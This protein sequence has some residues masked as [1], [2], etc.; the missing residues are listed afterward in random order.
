MEELHKRGHELRVQGKYKEAIVIFKNAWTKDN[1]NK[2]LGWEYAYS[3]K[4]IGNVKKAISICKHT[5]SL[6]KSFTINNDLMA[7]CVYE[8]YFREKNKSYTP[9]EIEK[10]E[11]ITQAI[12][13]LI[14]QKVGSAY[15]Y[16][17]F[18]LVTIYKKQGDK[19]SYEKTI[20]WLDKLNVDLLTNDTLSY[21]NDKMKGKILELSSRKEDYYATRTKSLLRLN[22]YEECIECCVR[23]ENEIKVY[24]YD[25]DIWIKEREFYSL[26]RIG[27]YEKAI[28]GLKNLVLKKEHWS[29]FFKIAELY[30]ISGQ[31]K[32]AMH[33]AYK[34]LLTR[35]PDKMKINVIY[36]VAKKLAELDELELADMHYSY[37]KKIREENE[38]SIPA[39]VRDH[40]SI[41]GNT[42]DKIS[43]AKMQKFWLKAI[44]DGE[45]AYNGRINKIMPNKRNGF[46][47][48][49]NR[50]IFFKTN[51]VFGCKW[52]KE[53]ADVSFIIEESY[54]FSKNRKTQEA[55][56]IEIICNLTK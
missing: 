33:Y 7:W 12:I 31:Q 55:K 51:N 52:V 11:K 45:N 13:S 2:W 25:N 15:E 36:F 3:L 19:R 6:D 9:H 49:G 50:S 39:E 30:E 26:G 37:Y 56:Y 35:D 53:K 22:R 20:E 21:V 44:K 8:Q 47:Q 40:I 41:L 10:L 54:D 38:W 32:S 27:D 29:F 5:Y 18:A 24:H 42:D 48:F 23:A 28:L 16:I 17:I 46:I 14:K 4:K 43:H 34:A 1:K